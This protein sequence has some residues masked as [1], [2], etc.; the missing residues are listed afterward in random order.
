MEAATFLKNLSN[1]DKTFLQRGGFSAVSVQRYIA[2]VSWKHF[3][4]H[5]HFAIRD[6]R[7]QFEIKLNISKKK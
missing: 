2:N 4:W 3:F 7:D 6:V 1:T 5:V